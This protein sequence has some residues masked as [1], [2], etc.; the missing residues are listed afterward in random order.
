MKNVGITGDAKVKVDDVRRKMS[1]R[2]R[3]I[4]TI[5]GN[6]KL[7]CVAFVHASVPYIIIEK[8]GQEYVAILYVLVAEV[9]RRF[10]KLGIQQIANKEQLLFVKIGT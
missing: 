6:S 7:C 5:R 10:N 1:K 8:M 4:L 9:E 3:R 2:C